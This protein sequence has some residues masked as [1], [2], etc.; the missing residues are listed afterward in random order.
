MLTNR[1]LRQIKKSTYVPDQLSQE[2][3]IIG[4]GL[5]FGYITIIIIIIELNFGKIK[6]I[7]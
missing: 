4:A 2:Q 3:L 1:F 6:I 5:G 7:M